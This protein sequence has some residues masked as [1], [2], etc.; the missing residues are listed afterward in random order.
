MA[1]AGAG[2]ARGVW[3]EAVDDSRLSNISVPT[4]TVETHFGVK[5]NEGSAA[6]NSWVCSG[7]SLIMSI[8]RARSIQVC[9]HA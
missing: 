6:P 7:R 8:S 1:V 3:V 4:T 9:L 2:L 5:A